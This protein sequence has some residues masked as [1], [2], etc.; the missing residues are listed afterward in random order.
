MQSKKRINVSS[1]CF[2]PKPDVASTI[3]SLENKQKADF[4]Y[5]KLEYIVKKSFSQRRKKIKNV[6]IQVSEY[7]E[8]NEY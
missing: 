4:D 7:K 1:N 5:Q 6:L 2:F 3:I 8:L